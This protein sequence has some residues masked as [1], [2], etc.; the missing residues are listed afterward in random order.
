MPRDSSG[1]YTLPGAYNP[2]V[3]N[4]TILADWANISLAD[5]ASG[6]TDSLDRSGRG[7]MFAALKATDGTVSAPGITFSSQTTLG[8]Y[9]AGSNQVAVTVASTQ[10]Q[11]WTSTG[12][13]ITGDASISGTLSAGA[14]TLA[15]LTLSGN[16]VVGGTTALNGGTTIGDAA[17]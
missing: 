14:V 3:P 2:V 6:I 4:T 5:I 16:L 10:R 12:T 7:G 11:V 9:R 1:N 17:G 8:I 15:S 13:D